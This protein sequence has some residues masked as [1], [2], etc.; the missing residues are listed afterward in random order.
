M[1]PEN[2]LL[3]GISQPRGVALRGIPNSREDTGVQPTAVQ[4]SLK[5]SWAA[6]YL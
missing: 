5:G 2:L 4:E 1:L 3:Q 6:H